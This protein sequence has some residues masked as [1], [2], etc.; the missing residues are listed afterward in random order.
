MSERL[1]DLRN[2]GPATEEQLTAVG[3][4]T[5][6]ELSDIGS[7]EAYRRLKA[8]YGSKVTLVFLYALE[9]ALL[10]LHWNRLPPEVKDEIVA[11]VQG[12]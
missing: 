5:P 7:V 9:G 1:R 4:T 2:L 11:A 3:I 12:S 10:D 8:R 6:E